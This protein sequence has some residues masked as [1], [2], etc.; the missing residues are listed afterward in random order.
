MN[1]WYNYSWIDI[2]EKL[3]SDEKIGLSSDKVNSIKA[4]SGIYH[5]FH[6]F[7]F[8]QRVGYALKYMPWRVSYNSFWF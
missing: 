1:D 4:K 3:D 5:A 6:P 7:Y 2:V 8:L